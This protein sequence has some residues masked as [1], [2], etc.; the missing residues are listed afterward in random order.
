MVRGSVPIHRRGVVEQFGS[1][2]ASARRP[3]PWAAQP[4]SRTWIWPAPVIPLSKRLPVA[5]VAGHYSSQG[6]GTSYQGTPAE[7]RWLEH[8]RNRLQPKI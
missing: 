8:V 4:L 6:K 1:E 5:K 3:R 7:R 2:C